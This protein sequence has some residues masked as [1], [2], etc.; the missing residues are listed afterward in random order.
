MKPALVI[1]HV[2]VE[3]HVDLDEMAE[4]VF[5][6]VASDELDLA[7]L[8]STADFYQVEPGAD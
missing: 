7:P 8:V 1:L 5:D 3:D 4:Q 6:L 2:M